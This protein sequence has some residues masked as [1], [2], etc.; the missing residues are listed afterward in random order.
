MLKLLLL[1]FFTLVS[2]WAQEELKTT[3]GYA[4]YKSDA[5]DISIN[6][7]LKIGSEEDI[8]GRCSCYKQDGNDW[9]CYTTVKPTK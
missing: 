8:V 4:Q 9:L 3:Q 1:F 2:L 6:K 5:C 7:A